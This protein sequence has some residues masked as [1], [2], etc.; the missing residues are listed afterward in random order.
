MQLVFMTGLNDN[1]YRLTSSPWPRVLRDMLLKTDLR[2]VAQKGWHACCNEAR[3]F[4][5]MEWGASEMQRQIDIEINAVV[6]CYCVFEKQGSQEYKLLLKIL[7][8]F[9]HGMGRSVFPGSH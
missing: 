3:G 5:L 2:G 6:G 4:P 8:S 7:G 1:P 9:R